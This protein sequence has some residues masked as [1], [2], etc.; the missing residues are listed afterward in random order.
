MCVAGFAAVEPGAD[1]ARRE[2][3]VRDPRPR[4]RCARAWFALSGA[5]RHVNRCM[6]ALPK[7]I[8]ERGNRVLSGLNGVR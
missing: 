2:A 3:D 4:A 5:A 7:E 6:L 8:R 1:E